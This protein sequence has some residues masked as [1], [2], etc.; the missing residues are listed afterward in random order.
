[1]ENPIGMC[2]SIAGGIIH[3]ELILQMN[4]EWRIRFNNNDVPIID[5]VYDAI[6]GLKW[7]GGRAHTTGSYL[8]IDQVSLYADCAQVSLYADC[9]IFGNPY[10]ETGG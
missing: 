8:S 2:W 4:L 1:M 6:P 10:W 7:S 5:N 9:A 3:R